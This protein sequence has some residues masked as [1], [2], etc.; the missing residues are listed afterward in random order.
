MG[1]IWKSGCS[2]RHVEDAHTYIRV[3]MY[4]KDE[5]KIVVLVVVM[6]GNEEAFR[7]PLFYEQERFAILPENIDHQDSER[8]YKCK[9]L[10]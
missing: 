3:S 8:Q 5:S 1:T 6:I 7:C 4:V 10:F 9:E 2:S